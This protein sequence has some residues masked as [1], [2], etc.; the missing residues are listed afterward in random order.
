MPS[1]SES[2]G[3]TPF[4]AVYGQRPRMGDEPPQPTRRLPARQQIDIATADKFAE[5][6]KE[7]TDYLHAEMKLA[8]A[9]YAEQADKSR[10]PG[11][12]FEKGDKVWLDT[13]NLKMERPSKKLL[14]RYIGPYPCYRSHQ[15]RGLPP[16]TPSIDGKP[17]RLP[18]Q[19]T[20]PSGDGP[21]ARSTSTFTSTCGH[22]TRQRW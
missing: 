2:T 20:P 13:R 4:Y 19:P 21:A 3:V 1:K 5:G 11:P 12:I 16:G 15:P 8:Q 9:R 22:G 7:L 18:H 17:Q 14:E 6:M 10:S